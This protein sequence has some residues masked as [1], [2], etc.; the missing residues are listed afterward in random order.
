MKAFFY[1]L[2]LFCLIGVAC[3]PAGEAE[4][5]APPEDPGKVLAETYCSSCHLYTGPEMLDQNTW[6]NFILIRMGAFMGIFYDNITYHDNDCFS[7]MGHL[8]TTC[9]G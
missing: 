3:A 8:E 6:K 4:K 7:G 5:Q 1:S 9:S 2:F